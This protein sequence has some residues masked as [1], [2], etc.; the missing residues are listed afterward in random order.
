MSRP[1]INSK[2]NSLCLCEIC[3]CG[4]H[5]CIPKTAE[6]SREI[7]LSS[8]DAHVSKICCVNKNCGKQ[9]NEQPTEINLYS[10]SIYKKDFSIKPDIAGPSETSKLMGTLKCEDGVTQTKSAYARDYVPYSVEDVKLFQ[11]KQKKNDVT[12]NTQV[13]TK[14]QFD[15]DDLKPDVVQRLRNYYCPTHCSGKVNKSKINYSTFYKDK[16]N[17]GPPS[18]KALL[19]MK[20]SLE[21]FSKFTNYS[22]DY[23]PHKIKPREKLLHHE[24]QTNTLIEPAH[25]R[26]FDTTHKS[27]YI[28]WSPDD[29]SE[30]GRVTTD[31]YHSSPMTTFNIGVGRPMDLHSSSAMDYREHNVDARSRSLKRQDEFIAPNCR[32]ETETTSSL[33]FRKWED[34]SVQAK[35]KPT[36]DTNHITSANDTTYFVT[37]YQ[38]DFDDLKN[39]FCPAKII[40][41]YGRKILE[42][43]YHYVGSENE[44]DYYCKKNFT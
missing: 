7:R 26:F 14:E 5:K 3:K 25:P 31:V 41:K 23:T 21:P 44:H 2:G 38:Q 29:Y 32:M 1:P 40:E 17:L 39:V 28:C 20:K 9:V 27:D 4:D 42:P 33:A 22:L 12:K 43:K 19:P 37:N 6:Q 18:R 36:K 15:M 13:K 24:S 10:K 11:L 30:T 35:V 34:A 16:F 8:E